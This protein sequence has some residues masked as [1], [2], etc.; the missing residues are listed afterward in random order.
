M[1]EDAGARSTPSTRSEP[2]PCASSAIVMDGGNGL[3]SVVATYA[4]REAIRR[5][6][7]TEATKKVR[8]LLEGI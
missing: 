4:M 2:L 5:A 8:R 3:D 1:A 6:G 7:E